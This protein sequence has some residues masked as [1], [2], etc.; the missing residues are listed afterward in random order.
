MEQTLHIKNKFDQLGWEQCLSIEVVDEPVTV[1]PAEQQ[2]NMEAY[3][4]AFID[5]SKDW[6]VDFG[7]SHHA[8]GNVF[9]VSDV[10]P[11]SGK[12]V[13]VIASNSLHP[14]VKEGNTTSREIFQMLKE[15]LS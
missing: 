10:R 1:N 2:T 12:R 4:N 3:S 5:Y 7:C 13:I 8:N 11:H 6:I 9:L 15:I 14:I